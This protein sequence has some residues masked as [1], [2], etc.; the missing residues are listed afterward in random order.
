MHTTN[1]VANAFAALRKQGF[2][3]RRNH[4]CCGGCSGAAIVADVEKM[5]AEKRVKIAG[6]VHYNRQSGAHFADGGDLY[7]SF[8]PVK[9]DDVEYGRPQ[10]EIGRALVDALRTAG[11]PVEWTGNP[12][13]CVIVR[14]DRH[15]AQQARIGAC[16]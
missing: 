7:V 6:A 5:P 2:I 14:G 16:L 15:L 3:A 8:S 10:V 12:L 13:D 1:P 4:M 9:I 11:A